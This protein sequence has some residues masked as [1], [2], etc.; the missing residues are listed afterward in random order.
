MG[1]LHH[2]ETR[3][4]RQRDGGHRRGATVILAIAALAA[5]V[6]YTVAVT[7]SDELTELAARADGQHRSRR[8]M[9]TCRHG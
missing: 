9:G 7:A 8:G 2:G 3:A 6:W 4:A 1:A 5:A